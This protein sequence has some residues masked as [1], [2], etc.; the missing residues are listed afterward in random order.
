MVPFV[1]L[2]YNALATIALMENA[3]YFLIINKKNN[4]SKETLKWPSPWSFISRIY[5]SKQLHDLWSLIQLVASKGYLNSIG[6]WSVLMA[7]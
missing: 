5:F 3:G 6:L 7:L 2:T 4:F 1:L